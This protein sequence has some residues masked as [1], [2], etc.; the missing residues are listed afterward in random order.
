[1]HSIGGLVTYIQA[2]A[3]YSVRYSTVFTVRTLIYK[4]RRTFDF[5]R[6]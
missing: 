1:M 6:T 3:L 5:G 4:E 2:C